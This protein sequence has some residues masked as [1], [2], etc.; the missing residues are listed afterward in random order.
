MFYL[1][2]TFIYIDIDK[3]QIVKIEYMWFKKTL[4]VH[5]SL[6]L[7]GIFGM[8]WVSEKIKLVSWSMNQ[9]SQQAPKF[10]YNNHLENF[11]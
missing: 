11:F 3:M 2:P 4:K 6:H 7:F 9:A 5:L 10:T 8:I 1:C